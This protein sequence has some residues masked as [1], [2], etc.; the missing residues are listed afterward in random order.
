M[1]PT[2]RK[3]VTLRLMLAIMALTVKGFLRR[4]PFSSTTSP[5][6]RSV[7][8]SSVISPRS[9]VPSLHSS[10]SL[11]PSSF[12]SVAQ[13]SVISPR[14]EVRS[15][16]SSFI[17]QPSA[18]ILLFICRPLRGLCGGGLPLST[19]LRPWLQTIA[20]WA[21]KTPNTENAKHGKRQ[22][23]KTPNTGIS[24]GR[25]TIPVRGKSPT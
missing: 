8:Q 21:K 9:E 10:F 16:E 12:S 11:P 3:C 18:F 2:P 23:R 17:L 1:P 24:C 19:G 20:L 15:P 14:S 4:V 6:S 13:S 5:L 25:N 22:T 7:A